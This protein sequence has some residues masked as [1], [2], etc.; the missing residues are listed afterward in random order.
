[1]KAKI[2]AD[3]DFKRKIKQIC[4]HAGQE[5]FNLII[6]FHLC[7]ITAFKVEIKNGKR[8]L[9]SKNC[10]STKPVHIAQAVN[11]DVTIFETGA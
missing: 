10:T 3:N 5:T 1:M 9:N 2:K 8:A 4:K 7:E 6:R 11:N